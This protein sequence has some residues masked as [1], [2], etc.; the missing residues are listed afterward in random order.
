MYKC[1]IYVDT[2]LYVGSIR[3]PV[4][5]VKLAYVIQRFWSHRAIKQMIQRWNDCKLF[6]VF[7]MTGI[8]IMED[9]GLQYFDNGMAITYETINIVFH[10]SN[11]RYLLLHVYS[12]IQI[13]NLFGH[14]TL[15]F[16]SYFVKH[17]QAKSVEH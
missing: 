2:G 4:N 12:I 1:F 5:M 13:I 7:H 6:T 8:L 3:L 14:N 15:K 9:V 16:L 11:Y 17:Y 10:Y